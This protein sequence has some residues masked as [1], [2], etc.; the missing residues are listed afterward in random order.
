[1]PDVDL[2]DRAG[3]FST[4]QAVAD[5]PDRPQPDD[6]G[7]ISY[8]GYQVVVA[9]RGDTIAS[10]AGRLGLEAGTLATFNGVSPDS[11][12]RQGEVVALPGRVAEPSAAT[13]ARRSPR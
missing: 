3:G 12:L 1:M 11:Q 13:R 2:R 4:A 8:P 9:R 5:L 10:I 6:R 7:V